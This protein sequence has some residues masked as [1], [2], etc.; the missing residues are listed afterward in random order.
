MLCEAQSHDHPARPLL[1]RS[2]LHAA[3][4]CVDPLREWSTD[5]ALTPSRTACSL[6][7]QSFQCWE[8]D[9]PAEQAARR[10]SP[11]HRLAEAFFE[12]R[13]IILFSG[14]CKFVFLHQR[15]DATQE[16]HLQNY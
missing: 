9:L 6:S 11:L 7:A 3:R 12:M 2:S 5:H 16:S 14:A 8:W 15:E 1:A 4:R 10:T 13:I